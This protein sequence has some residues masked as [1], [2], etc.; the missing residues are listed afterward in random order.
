MTS[1]AL[2]SCEPS[3]RIIPT[4][5]MKTMVMEHKEIL[6]FYLLIFAFD[7]AFG[8]FQRGWGGDRPEPISAICM[9]MPLV[10]MVLCFTPS[11]SVMVKVKN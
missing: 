6:A 2:Q 5:V 1:R 11:I 3:S 9:L 10:A 7:C 4:T 8:G